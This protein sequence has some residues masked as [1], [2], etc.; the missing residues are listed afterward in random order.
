M[1]AFNANDAVPNNEPEYI[2]NAEVDPPDNTSIFSVDIERDE[3]TVVSA[4]D[5]ERAN[6]A[7]VAND[8]VLG[9][10]VI[11]DAVAAVVANDD[12]RAFSAQLLVPKNPKLAVRGPVIRILLPLANNDPVN[13]NPAPPPPLTMNPPGVTP[14]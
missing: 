11:L 5:D 13:G 2:P 12:V 1:L 9:V 4:N 6:D 3:L 14:S 8:A 10:N 7:V